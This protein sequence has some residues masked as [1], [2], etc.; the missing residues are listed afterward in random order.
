V[1]FKLLPIYLLT[2]LIF[3]VSVFPVNISAEDTFKTDLSVIYVFNTEGKSLI[4]ENFAVTNLTSRYLSSNY[5]YRISGEVPGHLAGADSGGPL[6]IQTQKLDSGQTL[7][8]IIFNRVIPGKNHIQTFSISHDG[9]DVLTTD[10]TR[11]I[12]I[13][14]ISN[15]E[16][17]NTYTV[18]LKVPLEFGPMVYTSSDPVPPDPEIIKSYATYTFSDPQSLSAG[19]ISIFGNFQFKKYLLGYGL[20]NSSSIPRKQFIFLPAQIS[21]QK[22]LIKSINPVPA[23]VLLDNNGNWIAEYD[24]PAGG[25]IDVNVSG[26]IRLP[27]TYQNLIFNTPGTVIT[28]PQELPLNVEVSP[29]IYSEPENRLGFNWKPPLQ[30]LP[31]IENKGF[32]EIKNIGS[33][34][35]SISDFSVRGS[36]LSV[37][38]EFNNLFTVLP[39]GH[40]LIPVT[41]RLSLTDI[42]QPKYLSITAGISSVTYNIPYNPF[43]ITYGFITFLF[44]FSFL[45]LA[46]FAFRTWGLHLQ[47]R[48]K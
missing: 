29:D 11:K 25:Y 24:L 19:I 10:D 4:T 26:Q 31:F 18:K 22:V 37:I 14:K 40:I 9:P 1:P 30:I 33:A 16:Q 41:I 46:A 38:P 44:T 15:P 42:L 23:N 8:R 28:S 27:D 7:I 12:I 32:I 36:G 2:F 13:P 47:K 17:L 35:V 39:Y 43:L 48:G 6:L 21:G 3:S 20:S 5:E 34:S 45:G